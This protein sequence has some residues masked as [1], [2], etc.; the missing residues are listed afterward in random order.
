MI[1]LGPHTVTVRLACA[2]LDLAVWVGEQY[3]NVVV[4]P[5]DLFQDMFA[6]WIA[7]FRATVL[8]EL[9]ALCRL[10]VVSAD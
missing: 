6:S 8:R 9:G 3:G 4:L 5:I 7:A 1:R 10:G 2:L